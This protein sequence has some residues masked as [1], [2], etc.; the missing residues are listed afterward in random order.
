MSGNP[1]EWEERSRKLL[2]NLI[3]ELEVAKKVQANPHICSLMFQMKGWDRA[4]MK[5]R[6]RLLPNPN[7]IL[8][9]P[10]KPK[11][12]PNS[13]RRMGKIGRADA[14]LNQSPFP[15]LPQSKML[16]RTQWLPAKN[17][18]SPISRRIRNNSYFAG[19]RD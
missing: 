2:L 12:C 1:Q 4:K 19:C 7:P 3:Q 18:L 13:A 16:E 10:D 14:N 11:P 6:T 15:A 17:P 5:E 8:E 9:V